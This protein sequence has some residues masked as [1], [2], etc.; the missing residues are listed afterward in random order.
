VPASNL[1]TN[2][3]G[4]IKQKIETGF[5]INPLDENAPDEL[6]FNFDFEAPTAAIPKGSRVV[7]WV[8]FA[9]PNN[10]KEKPMSIACSTMVGD[11]YVSHVQTWKG[12]TS[13]KDTSKVVKNKKYNK[14]N[15]KEKAKKKDSFKLT[16]EPEW[17]STEELTAADGTAMYL[18]PCLAKLNMG[19]KM[20]E[21]DPF[22]ATYNVDM[23]V[24]VYANDKAKT[25]TSIPVQTATV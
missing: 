8:T 23:S 25:F 13:L 14:V 6:V 10:K 5:E 3:A 12:F 11:P 2:L 24:R 20:E 21:N 16:Q 15:K 1:Q 4:S 18:Q 9:N 22:F 7:Q 19:K 17:Y